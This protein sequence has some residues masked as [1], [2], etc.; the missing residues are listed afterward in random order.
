[1]FLPLSPKVMCLCYDGDVYSISYVNSW[2]QVKNER[3]VRHFNQLQLINCMANVYYQ[4]KNHSI[5]V[6]K[7]YK[8]I[9]H[10]RPEQRH[11]FNYAV[12]D[13]EENGYE[14]YRVVKK[15]ELKEH[16]NVL[17][18]YESIYP[19]PTTWPQHIR[20]RRNGSVFTND[21]RVGYIRY[22]KIKEMTSIGFRRE[23]PGG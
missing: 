20:A 6:S 2:A 4:D 18:H 3:D 14:R 21:T 17:F 13:Y 11:S 22:E 19:N 8:E 7:L 12:F 5:S 10:I 15:E 9:S 23:R 16:D 1:M